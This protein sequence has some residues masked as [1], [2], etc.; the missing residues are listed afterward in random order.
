M[1]CQ[2]GSLNYSD[3]HIL[4]LLTRVGHTIEARNELLSCPAT[5]IWG[6][7]VTQQNPAH[8]HCFTIY[9]TYFL[10]ICYRLGMIKLGYISEQDRQT[11]ALVDLTFS[12]GNR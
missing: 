5:E 9:L 10:S 7:F 11:S 1:L 3:G 6:V 12:E 8:Y 2:S 4:P